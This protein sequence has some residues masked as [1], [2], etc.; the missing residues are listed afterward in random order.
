MKRHTTAAAEKT[1]LVIDDQ[2]AL[3]EALL[4]VL[5]SGGFQALGASDGEAGLAIIARRRPDLILSDYYLPRG[6]G[7]DVLRRV[8]SL[9][10]L[11]G[12]PFVLMAGEAGP[13]LRDRSLAAG[14]AAFVPKACEARDLLATVSG[15][16]AAA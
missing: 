10:G 15:L 14:A 16:L 13:W 5:R 12:K 9:P 7:L 6:S 8:R 1:I 11:A 2:A 4:D 3:R